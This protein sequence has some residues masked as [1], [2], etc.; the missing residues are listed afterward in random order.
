MCLFSFL[1]FLLLPGHKEKC[2]FKDC[3]C[4]S[5]LVVV[6]RQKI[7]AA[8][9]AHLRQQRKVAAK[10]GLH[11]KEFS[12]YNPLTEEEEYVLSSHLRRKAAE[13]GLSVYGKKI[14]FT[15]LHC[16]SAN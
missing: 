2:E 8:R 14:M 4:R 7:T 13:T 10:R 1:T 12:E 5:C 3:T 9:V 6:E 15:F 16:Y 11:G